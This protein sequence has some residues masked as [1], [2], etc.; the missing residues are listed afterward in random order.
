MVVPL[1]SLSS[2]E[3]PS[4]KVTDSFEDKTVVSNRPSLSSRTTSKTGGGRR[5]LKIVV[6]LI[7]AAVLLITFAAAGVA[8][9]VYLSIIN[10]EPRPIV[11]RP[12]TPR[13]KKTPRRVVSSTPKRTPTSTPQRKATP[14]IET[15]PDFR[16]TKRATFKVRSDSEWQLSKIRTVGNENFRV[17]ATG[18][19]ELDDIRGSVSARG[20]SGHKD[21]RLFK[22]F[23]TGALLMRTHFPDG[24]H[25]NIQAVSSGRDWQNYPNE[26]GYLEFIVNDSEPEDNEGNLTIK[27]EM[28]DRP[29][30]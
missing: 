8:F 4:E 12:K 29:A 3:K 25:S 9:A 13:P 20:V 1:D 23:R 7:V 10:A 16:P 5:T 18:R 2:F 26:K 24:S 30:N 22:D 28:I 15:D 19:Y 21:R 27:F 11:S 17:I 14:L 6:G